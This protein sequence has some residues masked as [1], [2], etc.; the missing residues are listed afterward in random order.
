MGKYVNFL[1]PQKRGFG[2]IYC[3][4]EKTESFKQKPEGFS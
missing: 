2:N 4:A 3:G 1:L